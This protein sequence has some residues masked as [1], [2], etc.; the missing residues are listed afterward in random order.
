MPRPLPSTY[1]KEQ[2][3]RFIQRSIPDDQLVFFANALV[4]SHNKEL[5]QSLPNILHFVDPNNKDID[6]LNHEWLSIWVNIMHQGGLGY[7][8][9]SKGRE[10]TR[11]IATDF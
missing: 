9:T 5:H 4:E 6:S 2:R 3:W 10:E 8:I 11:L 1:P 7:T